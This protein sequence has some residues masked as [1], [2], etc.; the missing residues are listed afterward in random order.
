MQVDFHELPGY[1]PER[2]GLFFI[3]F[4][5]LATWFGFLLRRYSKILL[6]GFDLETDPGK[7]SLL[8]ETFWWNYRKSN[9]E[10]MVFQVHG[11]WWLKKRFKRE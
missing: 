9:K 8:L 1:S 3:H 2:F 11:G 6:G 7:A 5:R 10:H 4:I